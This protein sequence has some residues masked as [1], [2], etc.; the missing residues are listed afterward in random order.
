[1]NLYIYNEYYKMIYIYVGNPKK[2]EKDN[3]FDAIHAYD[4]NDNY[5]G[6]YKVEDLKTTDQIYVFEVAK[7]FNDIIHFEANVSKYLHLATILTKN[8]FLN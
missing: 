7:I 6:M 2:Y 4:K 8:Q 5:I 1:M 3:D